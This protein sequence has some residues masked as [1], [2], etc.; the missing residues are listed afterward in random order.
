MKFSEYPFPCK[1]DKP[2]KHQVETVKAMLSWKKLYVLNT[3]GTG[4]T[5]SSLWACDLL[6]INRKINKVLVIMPL[7]TMFAVW[8]KEIVENIP[9]RRYSI[10]HGSKQRRIANLEREA[11]F[12]L[13]NHDGIKVIEDEIIKAKFDIIVI[14]ELTAYKSRTADRSKCMLRIARSAK[15]VWGMTG[16][17]MPHCPTEVYS[18]AKIVNP[19]NPDFEP[20]FF[21]FR[22][23]VVYQIPF[24]PYN[25]YKRDG[26]EHYIAKILQPCIRFELRQ[27]VDL[28]PVVFEDRQ[29]ELSPEQKRAYKEM[30][31]KYRTQCE[32]GVITA[33]NAGVKWGKLL[34]ISSGVAYGTNKQI[35]HLD[36]KG[37]LKELYEIFLQTEQKKLI[38]FSM[39]RAT[40]EVIDTYLTDKGVS[41]EMIMGG[42]SV[43]KRTRAISDF[44]DGDLN[45][46]IVQPKTASHGLTLV[47]A[48]TIVW[49]TPP[50]SNESYQQANARISRPGQSRTQV[51]IRIFSTKSEEKSYKGIESNENMSKLLFGLIKEG[52]EI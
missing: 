19:K 13:I 26:A 9:H 46:L 39:F 41:C 34:Q 40:M 52:A 51:I 12:Y 10:L 50:P 43:M 8:A 20:K 21:K 29:V 24:D 37:K 47:A 23:K 15:A 36:C 49:F 7:S 45:V 27:C 5:L 32:E 6:M 11:D 25:W 22:D 31:K 18:Q 4:K 33:A 17:P 30:A 16:D 44:Q 3:M 28:P 14:D 38:V 42:M 48:N 1:Y 2:Y 35:V